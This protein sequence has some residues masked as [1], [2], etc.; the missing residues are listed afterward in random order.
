[1]SSLPKLEP[2]P[3]LL[4]AIMKVMEVGFDPAYGEAWTRRQ[5]CDALNFPATHCLLAD[6]TGHEPRDPGDTVGFALSRCVVD[7]EELLLI[8][9]LPQLRS[10]GI[11]QVLLDRFEQAAISRGVT[12]VF[13]EMRHNNQA[14]RLYRRNGYEQVGLRRDYY[15]RGT[16]GPIDA[17]TFAKVIS[18]AGA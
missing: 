7:E 11:G 1:M 6:V 12:R 13:L 15:R 8:A 2:S 4:D 3:D 9:V 17:L 16:T 18:S 10:R 14:G 5:I